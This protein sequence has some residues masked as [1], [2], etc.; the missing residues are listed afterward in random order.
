MSSENEDKKNDQPATTSGLLFPVYAGCI[1]TNKIAY[2]FP[3]FAA[4]STQSQEQ[5]IDQDWLKCSS[6]VAGG[7][8]GE[9][10]CEQHFK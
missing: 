8:K 7:D 9:A 4:T 1:E 10:N 2:A 6:F 3:C 5:S